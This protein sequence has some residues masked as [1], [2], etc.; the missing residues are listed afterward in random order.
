MIV[1][2]IV[3]SRLVRSIPIAP[4]GLGLGQAH[5]FLSMRSF[6]LVQSIFHRSVLVITGVVHVELGRI[7]MSMLVMAMVGLVPLMGR[8]GHPLRY[9]AARADR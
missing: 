1:V 4:D 2:L 3:L 9:I 6:H 8:A 7:G 5:V